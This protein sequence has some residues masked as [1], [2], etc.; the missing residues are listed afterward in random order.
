MPQTNTPLRYPG[1][2]SKLTTFVGDIFKLNNLLDGTYVEPYAGGAGLAINL[3]LKGIARYIYLND[4]DRS[5]Y[6]FWHSILFECENFCS[7]IE[8]TPVTI[9]EWIKQKKIQE[10][11]ENIDLLAL[12]FSTFFLNRTNRSG[13]LTAGVIGGKSQSGNY[14]INARFNKLDLLRKIRLINLYRSRI[15]ISNLDAFKFLSTNSEFFPKNTFINLDPPYYIKG[16]KL[17]QNFYSHSD[18]AVIANFLPFLEPYWMVT[19]DNVKPIQTLYS[20]YPQ[21]EYTL[22]YTAQKRYEGNELLITDPRLKIPAQVFL[23]VS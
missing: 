17:Y 8:G 5:I 20:R 1:G 7:L 16:Q 23:K 10:D 12:G 18:H 19:Y 21:L 13:I 3:L 11:K 14:T 6:A 22:S 2:K 15:K 9:D 4:L